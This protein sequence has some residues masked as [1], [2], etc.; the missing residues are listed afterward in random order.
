M[1]QKSILSLLVFAAIFFAQIFCLVA[2]GEDIRVT[3]LPCPLFKCISGCPYGYVIDQNG[4]QTCE[5]NPCQFGQPLYKF[6]CGQGQGQCSN[7]RGQC[8]FSAFDN[9]Y[10]CPRERP[11][12]CPPGPDPALV[13]CLPATC[14]HDFNCRVGQ[15][16]CGPCFQCVNATNY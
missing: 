2:Q 6:S 3:P 15:K 13:L 9:A 14:K 7:N 10:C 11:G 8:K 1:Q 5:C 4:C 12:C 16:C